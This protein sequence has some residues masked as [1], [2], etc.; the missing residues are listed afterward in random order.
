NQYLFSY[1]NKVWRGT[2]AMQN[3]GWSLMCE[4]PDQDYKNTG[5]TMQCNTLAVLQGMQNDAA[6]KI[7]LE[8][9]V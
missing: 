5:V 1:N 6:G 8:N 3:S 4:A 2:V 7:I 9:I